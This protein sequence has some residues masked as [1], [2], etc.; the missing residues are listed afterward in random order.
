MAFWG[1]WVCKFRNFIHP[2]RA[3]E[4]LEREVASH[5]ALLQDSFMRKGMSAEESFWAA[6]R[7]YGGIEQAKELHRQERSWF[8]L[9]QLR[10]DIRFS[11]RSLLK[12]P[13][14][15]ITVVLT[16]ALGI[17]ANTAIF[18]LIDSVMLKALPVS[19]PEQLLQ[20]NMGNKDV[21]G[22]KNPFLSNP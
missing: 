1:R 19:H 7:A 17:G 16:L 15:S 22:T 14:F 6:R 9:E 8:W 5:L 11:T 18:S 3:E 13:G 10:Q 21:W 4:E 2:N 20:V 12:T